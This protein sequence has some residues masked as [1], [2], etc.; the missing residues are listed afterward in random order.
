MEKIC[1]Y[2]HCNNTLKEGMRKHARFCQVKCKVK[3]RRI[4]KN[5]EKK[6]QKT[7]KEAQ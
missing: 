7:K 6:L 2:K 5:L 4:I 3:N 1:E